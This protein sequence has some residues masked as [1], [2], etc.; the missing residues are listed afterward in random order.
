MRGIETNGAMWGRMV[1][2]RRRGLIK[3][4]KGVILVGK[5]LILRMA[6]GKLLLEGLG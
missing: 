1:I 4:T 5:T 2:G 6:R 3:G